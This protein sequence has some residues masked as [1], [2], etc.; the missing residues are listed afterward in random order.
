[1]YEYNA[2]IRYIV[3]GDTVDVDIDLG[4]DVWLRDQRIRLYGI[5]T[6]ECRTR[7]KKEKAH[8]LLAK[9]Y[10]EKALKLERSILLEQKRK[11][12]LGVTWEKSKWD[13]RPSM[14]YSLKNSSPYPIKGKTKKTLL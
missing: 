3:D 4:F 5:D 10:V 2:T 9:D 6:P 8:G 13:E 1:M 7:N 11:A 12:S 14:R